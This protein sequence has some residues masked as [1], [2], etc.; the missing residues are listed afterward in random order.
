MM[1]FVSIASLHAVPGEVTDSDKQT[2]IVQMAKNATQQASELGSY[3]V[4]YVKNGTALAQIADYIGSYNKPESAESLYDT[5]Q[6]MTNAQWLGEHPSVATG[7]K[8]AALVTATAVTYW[9]AK[10]VAQKYKKK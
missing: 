6:L 5:M 1:S 7:M 2:V 8:V 10:K 4:N 3:A 9:A